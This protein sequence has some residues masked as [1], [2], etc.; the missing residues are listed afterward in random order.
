M[1]KYKYFFISLFVVVGIFNS[2]GTP[3]LPLFQTQ[4]IS[5]K[6]TIHIELK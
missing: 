2:F 5:T 1:K 4:D 6:D 3:S